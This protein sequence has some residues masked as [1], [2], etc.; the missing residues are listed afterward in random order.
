MRHIFINMRKYWLSVLIIFVLLVLQAFCDFSLP[1]YTSK[2]IDTGITNNGIEYATP[3]KVSY[4]SYIGVSL[5]MTEDELMLW[6]EYYQPDDQ[7]VYCLVDGADKQE[8]DKTFVE[9]LA[10]Y[11]IISQ[12]SAQETVNDSAMT[13]QTQDAMSDMHTMR[14]AIQ[15]KL[16]EL[17]DSMLT[18]YAILFTKN[19]YETLGVDLVK[20]RSQYLWK[21]GGMMLVFAMGMMVIAIAVGYLA[22]K[23][24]AGVGRDLRKKV[25][26]KVVRFSDGEINKFSTASLIT[27]TTNDVQQIQMVTVILLRLVLYAP[28]MAVG[29]I[30][31]VIRT[32][33]GMGYIIVM[34]VA[35][36]A[37]LMIC[38][39][40]IAMPKFKMMQKLVD[41]VN[42]VSREILTGI[43]VIRAFSREKHEEK[44]F[45]AANKELT[46]VMLFTN[47]VMTFMMPILMIIMNAISVLIVW[48][49]SHR[50]D[51]GVMEVGTMTAFIT[52]TMMIVMS[53]LMLTM[54]SIMLPRAGVAADRI[55]EV[56]RTKV[57]VNDKEDAITLE[58]TKG[59]VKFNNVSFCYP[60]AESNV[61]ENIDFEARPGT[62]TAIIGSTG[63]GKSTL[64]NLIPRF[65]DVTEGSVTVDGKDV[66]DISLESLRHNIGYV[67][68]KGV[69]FSG[70]IAD[71]IKYGQL[72]DSDE[73]M[74]EAARIAQAVEFIDSKPDRYDSP[75]SQG[76]TNVSGGQKQRLSIARAIAR[77]PMIYIFD[78]SFSALDFKTDAAL[79]KAL[80]PK[81][82]DKTVFI[83]AQRI[84][85]ILYA[86]QIIV[87]DDGKMVG[88]GTHKE[89]MKSCDVYKQIATSQLSEKE[90]SKSLEEE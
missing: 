38:L 82:K 25:F 68:Q 19:E 44:R 3:D 73:E 36:I 62:T 23:V 40:V 80:G 88:K 65:F 2:L 1:D 21:T 67:P 5:I 42:L 79:R 71:N 64:I 24:G 85:T 27:R 47:R 75:I 20:L 30:I 26:E 90:L 11:S 33:A 12:M 52:Y 59:I 31:M 51:Q 86:E 77:N 28:V 32:G 61:L 63:C 55:D 37:V 87:L 29:G 83:V 18:S 84:S 41:K 49:A 53:F 46:G 66:R 56:L 72:K 35:A 6:Q 45:D 15:D 9:P 60:D 16:S 69:L 13:G 34:A 78:D 89:L 43:P 76:G 10:V 4:A 8:L 54:V 70:T 58:N 48:T 81:V 7:G 17:G 39:L 50:I 22:S 57:S 74:F 14:T